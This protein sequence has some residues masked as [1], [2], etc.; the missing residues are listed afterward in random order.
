MEY[1]KSLNKI[2][3]LATQGLKCFLTENSH[4]LEID[5]LARV[6]CT[7]V[8]AGC[9]LQSLVFQG[10]IDYIFSAAQSD[11]GWADPEETAW[12]AGFIYK[13]KGEKDPAV[14]KAIQWLKSNRLNGGGWGKHSRDRARIP[15]TALVLTLVPEAGS[16]EDYMWVAQE[17][18]KDL[19]GSVQLSYKAGFYLLV[20]GHAS[21]HGNLDLIDRT[22]RHL[23]DDQN[24]DGGFG[25]WKNH[26]IGSDP[27]STGVVLWGLSKWIDRVDPAVIERALHWL[28]VTQLPTGYWPYHYLDEG[29]SYALIGAVS[30]MRA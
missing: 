1:R 20:A 22:I 9:S 25:P 15:T 18:A 29:T 5:R 14:S 2:L 17:W 27:W 7:L 10:I 16:D 30:A 26:P 24:D 8:M 11:G 23:I 28:E 19:S 12:V 6:L 3:Y 13:L 21:I 4:R